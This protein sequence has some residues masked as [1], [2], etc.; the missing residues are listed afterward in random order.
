MPPGATIG[1]FSSRD[2]RLAA[3]LLCIVTVFRLWFS[4]RLE[5]VGDEA[6]YWLWSRHF[7]YCYLDKGP[8]IAWVIKAS[9]LFFGSTVFGVRFFAVT[10]A[11]GTGGG[12]FLLARRLFDDR[13]ALW[14][15]ALALI[16]PLFAVGAT[17]MTIDTLHVLFWTWAAHAF[18]RAKDSESPFAWVL[19]GVLVGAGILS[20]YTALVELIAFAIFCACS[21]ADRRHLRQPGFWLMA[22]VSL[23][24]LLPALCWN[25]QHAWPTTHW[26]QQ[27][28]GLD[29][30]WH[31][32]PLEALTFFGGQAGVISPLLFGGLVAVACRPRTATVLPVRE[33]RFALALFL[34]L[35]LLYQILSFQ[36]AGQPNWAAA[37]YIGGLILLA[38][39]W[40]EA[41]R[42][43]RWAR[44]L[45]AAALAVA[46]LET[47]VLHDSAW[48][49]LPSGKDPL[50]RA[51]GSR[52]L[53]AAVARAQERTG[54]RFVI[55]NRYMTSA[56][57][58]FY[59]PG[60]P[61]TYVLP[62]LDT[63]N[64]MLIW[65]G[66]QKSHPKEDGLFVSDQET[67][68]RKLRPDFARVDL[69]ESHDAVQD[70]RLVK[71]FYIFWCQR[72]AHT[73]TQSP[74]TASAPPAAPS[75]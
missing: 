46:L 50:D 5:L 18:W 21:P 10:A 36:R 30:A 19:A 24:F 63:L 34:P 29:Q 55:T 60:Q 39:R 62:S 73:E 67:A 28:G 33:T 37:A 70:G 52:D 74:A 4:T 9:T 35:L 26:L 49:H 32:R 69:L 38:R 41:V 43:H 8:M 13:T 40:Q 66:Y 58:S 17:L 23:L 15:L 6:Y 68:P 59:L 61:A 7:D 27:R 65:P 56:L 16:V 12:I 71:R 11:A 31:V 25:V 45:A 64:Q 72:A 1:L 48:L 51:R 53:A 42:L 54:A 47:A 44:W 57:M 22:G 14:A 3:A 75:A 20:K 2:A